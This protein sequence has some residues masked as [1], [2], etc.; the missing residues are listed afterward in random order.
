VVPLLSEE[1]VRDEVPVLAVPE[2]LFP[3]SPVPRE[4][5]RL[6]Q[7]LG[8]LVVFR[9]FGVQGRVG[10]HADTVVALTVFSEHHPPLSALRERLETAGDAAMA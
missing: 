8:R 9:D 2:R 10:I 5:Q 3:E 4:P 7:P 6:Q 1:T